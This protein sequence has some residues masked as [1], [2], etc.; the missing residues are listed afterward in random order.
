MLLDDGSQPLVVHIL[1]ERVA[2]LVLG[3]VQLQLLSEFA[4]SVGPFRETA[5]KADDVATVDPCH[6]DPCIRA[7]HLSSI[8]FA[9]LK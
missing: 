6:I 1:Q 7:K 5:L 2:R 3:L 4:V 9:Q 8:L